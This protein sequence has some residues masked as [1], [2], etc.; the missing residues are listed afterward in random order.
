MDP[1][2]LALDNFNA[3]GMFR[4]KEF[5]QPIDPTGQLI[6]GES[7]KQIRELKHV[8][9]T[10]RKL[11]FYRTLAEK[12]LT[13]AIGRGLEFYDVE[14]VDQLVERLDRENGRCLALLQGVIE[15]SPF[16]QRRVTAPALDSEPTKPTGQ[17][18]EAKAKP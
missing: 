4:E 7:F 12:M 6:T 14:S 13:Y 11:D 17:R 15:S 10:D 8:L 2:G 5:G 18:A 1:L 16:Q 3:M 9:A